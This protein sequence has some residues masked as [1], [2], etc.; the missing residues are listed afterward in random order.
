MGKF[1]NHI[2]DEQGQHMLKTG[3]LRLIFPYGIQLWIGNNKP[4]FALRYNL[5]VNNNK[6]GGYLPFY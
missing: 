3:E 4:S 2:L 5:I 1:L 6:Y